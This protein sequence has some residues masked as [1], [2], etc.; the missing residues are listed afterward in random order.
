M[1]KDKRL[2]QNFCLSVFEKM[3]TV[4]SIDSKVGKFFKGLRD[5]YSQTEATAKIRDSYMREMRL[6]HDN[7]D[8][9][10]DEYKAWEPE[11]SILKSK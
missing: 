10:W 6:S 1:F 4:L 11:E 8:L 2:R 5:I 3:I 7:Y 9:V